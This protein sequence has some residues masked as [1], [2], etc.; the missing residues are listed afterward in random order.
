MFWW[1]VLNNSAKSCGV[2]TS[3][4]NEDTDASAQAMEHELP[5]LRMSPPHY[6]SCGSTRK[7][8]VPQQAKIL[9]VSQKWHGE[10]PIIMVTSKYSPF[11][12]G[13]FKGSGWQIMCA[14]SQ[15]L[16]WIKTTKFYQGEQ[17]HLERWK[18]KV[19]Q[20]IRGPVQPPGLQSWT[21]STRPCCLAL[22]CTRVS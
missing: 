9:I 15:T 21:P 17:P 4:I 5:N 10:G 19:T 1:K 22:G 16:S 6:K 14:L 12:S 13:D 20:Q 7:S 2:L 8:H 18:S 3:F 11:S